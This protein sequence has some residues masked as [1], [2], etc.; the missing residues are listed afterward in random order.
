MYI[1][2]RFSDGS[3]P[4]YC[5]N[6]TKKQA[7]KHGHYFRKKY[8]EKAV[9]FFGRAGSDKELTHDADGVWFVRYDNKAKIYKRLGDALN[10][11]LK[12]DSRA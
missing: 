4:W 10:F 11:L 1:L 9:I 8:G 5:I 12:E 6:P 7:L 2:V 3:N